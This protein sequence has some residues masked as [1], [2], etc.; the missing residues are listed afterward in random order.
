MYG[1]NPN[2]AIALAAW[3]RSKGHKPAAERIGEKFNRLTIRSLV[4]RYQS[5]WWAL[6]DCDCGATGHK[7]LLSNV[8]AGLSRSCGCLADEARRANATHGMSKSDE[9]GV[10]NGMLDRCNPANGHKDYG[11]RGIRVCDRW[12]EFE[13]FFADMGPRPSDGHSIDRINTNG[14]YEP[15]N[16]RWATRAEQSRNRRNNVLM[17]FN[18]ATRLVSDV[19]AEHGLSRQCVML[20]IKKG[21]DAERAATTPVMNPHDAGKLAAGVARPNARGH[22]KQAA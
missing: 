2:A 4:E 7:A 8:V 12:A 9:Y 11:G 3:H 19:G 17:I 5:T 22:R 10:W 15:S 20:R 18:G 14:N 16:C 6:V 13:N 21:W 1:P